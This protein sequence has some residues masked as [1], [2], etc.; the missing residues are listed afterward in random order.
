MIPTSAR[1]IEYFDHHE[2]EFSTE[3]SINFH[4][5]HDDCV[6]CE[7]SFSN[8]EL[9]LNIKPH[10]LKDFFS[11]SFVP[12]YKENFLKSNIPSFDL[13]GPPFHV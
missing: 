12:N 9:K 6:T 1:L 5:E 3:T 2:H 13:R 11:K 8:F 7:F 4:Q 10:V